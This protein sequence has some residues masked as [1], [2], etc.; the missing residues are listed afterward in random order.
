MCCCALENE[1]NGSPL[2]S[3]VGTRFEVAEDSGFAAIHSRAFGA[4]RLPGQQGS[5]GSEPLHEARSHVGTAS[6]RE[7]QAAPLTYFGSAGP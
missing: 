1:V 6:I 2:C 5:P 3:S 7:R 4:W